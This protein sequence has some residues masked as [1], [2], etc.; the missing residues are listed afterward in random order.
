MAESVG[1]YF[2]EHVPAAIATQLRARGISVVTAL[3]ACRASQEI[4]DDQQLAFETQLNCVLV[5][6]DHHFVA[7]SATH[8]PHSGVVYF[9]VKLAIGACFEY[10]ELLALTTSMEEMRNQLV[11]GNW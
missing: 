8:Q 4:P 9:P 11:Y 1:Y 6:E 5:T 3:E 10:L 7:L 2:D